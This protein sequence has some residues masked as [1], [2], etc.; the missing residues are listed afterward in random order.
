MQVYPRIASHDGVVAI[1]IQRGSGRVQ[2]AGT[3]RISTD[4][5]VL[6]PFGDLFSIFKPVHLQTHTHTLDMSAILCSILLFVYIS[7]YEERSLFVFKFRTVS[8]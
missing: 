7:K 6:A 3:V 4:A 5:V 8:D 1:V 2:G